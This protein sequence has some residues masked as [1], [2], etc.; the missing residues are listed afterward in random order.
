[1]INST[2]RISKFE[3]RQENPEEKA[4]I[5]SKLTFWWLID[6]FKYGLHNDINEYDIYR[7]RE[8][9]SSDNL[10]KVFRKYWT[11]EVKSGTN[12]LWRVIRRAFGWKIFFVGLLYSIVDTFCR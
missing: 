9:D 3:N 12:N 2:E 7:T 6:L 1:M 11:E 8:K 5:L 4:G 10:W